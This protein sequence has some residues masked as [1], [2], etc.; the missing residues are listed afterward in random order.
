MHFF[1]EGDYYT[2][3]PVTNEAVR[4]AEQALGFL[5]PATYVALL[6]ER[7]G[8][9]PR[10]RCFPTTFSNTW[11]SDHIAIS[12]ILGVGTHWWGIDSRWG[13][14]YLVNEWEYPDI[15]IVICDAPSGGHDTVM[16]D[17]ATCGAEGEPSVAYIDED[18]VPRQLAPTF[19]GFLEGLVSC[20]AFPSSPSRG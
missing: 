16:L 13:S 9:T 2:G 14:R 17:Y 5:L 8:G 3:L 1:E 20:E 15:G 4:H 7:N 18:R 12:G 11:A 10:R 6:R 19:A